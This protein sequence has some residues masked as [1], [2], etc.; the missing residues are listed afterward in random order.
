MEGPAPLS[1]LRPIALLLAVAL[2]TFFTQLGAARLWD[3]DEPR[4]ARCA[5]EMWQRHDW[6]V[7]TFNE[8][9]RTHKP[10]LL[11]WCMM[12]AYELFGV[13]EFAARFWSAAL[14]LVTVA[15]TYA[16]GRRLF[17]PPAGFWA[18]IV[19]AT[20]LMFN[21]AARAATPDSLLI[22]CCTLAL[23]AYVYGVR[24]RAWLPSLSG[25]APEGME[26]HEFVP[27]RFW[28]AVAVY[29]AMG[30][31]VLAKGPIGLVLP[32]A[33][34]GMFLLVTTLPTA[35]PTDAEHHLLVVRWLRRTARVF[36]PLHFLRTCWRMRPLTALAIC[37]LV[38][39]PWYFLVGVRTE[40]QWLRGFLWE[41]N[42]SRAL[43]TMEGHR[44]SSL[45]YYPITLLVGTFPW[46]VL[47]IPLL[48]SL[49][50]DWRQRYGRPAY[51]LLLCWIGVWV[52]A[53]SVSQT[54][55]P[56]YITPTHPAVAVLVGRFLQ[57]LLQSAPRRS[58]TWP[59]VS[60]LTLASIGLVMLIA[61][62]IA[63]HF[64]LPGDELLGLLGV[65]PLAGGLMMYRQLQ[66]QRVAAAVH[67][68]AGSAVAFCIAL[69]GWVAPQVS[70]HQ[71]IHGLLELAAQHGRPAPLASYGSPE[72]SWIFYASR[73][74]A[75]LPIEAPERAVRF[76]QQDPGHRLLT[77]GRNYRRLAPCL[78][79][80]VRVVGRIPYFLKDDSVLLLANVVAPG[81]AAASL[82][83][84]NKAD[85][86]AER[87]CGTDRK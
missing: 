75:L 3:R 38:A 57:R 15:A 67:W 40:G 56:S 30:L 65:I 7:P 61:L 51:T 13:S 37:A 44:G 36:H 63:A 43:N 64:Y 50:E 9:L 4:N 35:S 47:T 41:H 87:G 54:K 55:L 25:G 42:V 34:L 84:L 39:G 22:C 58:L 66:Q 49:R 48:L 18:A 33:V 23:V 27:L 78:P 77:T 68:L 17:D 72:P 79:E 62:P 82:T 80:S 20:T 46:S 71:Q 21:V 83:A 8:E 14:A 76:M 2:V 19:L 52:A 60:A 5:Y 32:T 11:Y 45:L 10:V 29:G 12:S 1:R 69:F 6:V 73:P 26:V 16:L 53:F 59:H 81:E 31:G 70:R 24:A 85:N 86:P 74:V 28:P